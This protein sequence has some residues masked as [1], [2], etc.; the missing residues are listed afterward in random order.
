MARM[1]LA[2]LFSDI[3]GSTRLL[4]SLGPAY[5]DL[6]LT[7]RRLLR[8]AFATNS[9]TE[10]GTEGDSFFVTFP[11]A[12]DAV[13]AALAGQQALSGH[14]WPSPEI[15]VRVRMG[16]HLGEVELL[17]D[18]V[19][20]L[21]VHETAR[22]SGAGHGG[23]VLVSDTVVRL[24]E[25]VPDGVTW[26]DLGSYALK[27]VPVPLRISQLMH[28]AL[29]ARFPPIRVRGSVRSN[30]PQQAS[31]FIG[32]QQEVAAVQELLTQARLVTVTGTGGVGKTRIA[33]RVAADHV[34][35]FT[36]GVCLVDLAKVT[37][38]EGVLAQFATP[39]LTSATSLGE[40]VAALADRNVLLVVDNCEHV[41]TEVTP[42]VSQLITATSGVSVL[43]TS[44]ESLGVAGEVVWRVPPMTPMDARRLL[45]AR[46]RAVNA[47]FAITDEN[48]QAVDDVC[49]RLD[50]IPLALELAAA[51][52]TSLSVQQVSQRLDQRF[53]LLAGGARGTLERHR[54]LQATVDWSYDHLE[55]A[56]QTML[57]RL[58]VF[59]GGFSLDGAE[60]VAGTGDGDGDGDAMTVLDTIDQLVVKSLVIAEYQDG[61]SRYRLLETIR[62]YALDRLAATDEALTIREAHLR[63]V[64]RLCVE[65]EHGLWL[66]RD[67]ARLLTRLDQEQA[68]LRAAFDWAMA[69]TPGDAVSIL[70]ATFPWIAA[71]GRSRDWVEPCQR[72]LAA[73][74]TPADHGLAQMLELWLYSNTGPIPTE[75]IERTRACVDDLPTDH[76]PWLAATTRAYLAA[77]GY[78]SGDVAGAEAAIPQCRRVLDQLRPDGPCVL[79]LVL[80]ALVWVH[81]DAGQLEAARSYADEGLVAAAACGTTY[82]ESRMALNRARVDLA[83]GRKDEAR[84]YAERASSIARLTGDAFV[85]TVAV[86]MLASIAEGEGRFATARDLVAGIIDGVAET[87]VPGALEQVLSDLERY[88]ALASPLP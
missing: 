84:Q 2:V 28:P 11:T 36:D 52:L 44:R 47:Q 63:W 69:E 85:A 17:D 31:S 86:R 70:L 35:Q 48:R 24:A 73:S 77:W 6:L 50:A 22:L 43:A 42:I 56:E 30:L 9:G 55:P 51:R 54:T 32:R 53:R 68:N 15:T 81:L 23:Q 8:D 20:G 1:T 60:T 80:Q 65:S 38:P 61:T 14:A 39:L 33:L 76:M 71:R 59:V 67:L 62:Q 21:V 46:A 57:R 13:A 3:E 82:M 12:R 16:I 79:G 4:Q 49:Q 26:H 18:A 45:D 88:T 58:G 5:A 64:L 75:L 34:E 74:L 19:I 83:A 78:P 10:R 41:L 25:P 37:D 40:L 27:D 7:H 72:L 87:Q 66:G 29:T